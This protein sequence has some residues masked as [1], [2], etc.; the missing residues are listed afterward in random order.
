MIC[1]YNNSLEP[2]FN[3][4]V[5]EHLFKNFNDD[6]FM[7]WRNDNAIIVGKHQ[8]TLAE[9]NIDYV[10]QKNIK[11]VRRLSGGGAVFH[12]LGNLN[13]TFIMNSNKDMPVDFRK[14]TEPIL[15]VLHQLGVPAKFEGRNDLTIDGKKFSGN[16][17]HVVRN[18]VLQHGTLLFSS[19]MKDLSEA[20]KI[21][22]VKY[23][24]KAVKSVRSRVTNI[25]E[26]LTEQINLDRFSEMI[27]SH[28]MKKYPDN[29]T[30]E[31]N[32]D[33]IS[34]INE[35]VEKKYSTWEWNFGY[36][37]KYDFNRII[38]TDGGSIEINFNVKDGIISACK[39]FGDYFNNLETEDFENILIG[40]RHEESS[41]IE[42]LDNVNVQD[43]FR[44][45]SQEQLVAGMF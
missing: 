43:Y 20:L 7:L 16:A 23:Q 6:I 3:M 5:E 25:S 24:D 14:Y 36:Q 44:N 34:V 33:D 38:K 12:D 27:M 31:F 15:E 19:E 32:V 39:I 13:F 1:I 30:Y 21:H 35:L 37:A 42:A 41:I 2:Y 18:R 17:M 26:H 10:K 9:I 8:N 29:M 40:V 4:A 28:I 11:V 22:P 45:V